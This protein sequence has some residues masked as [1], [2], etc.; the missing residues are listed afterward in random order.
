M[1]RVTMRVLTIIALLLFAPN[2]LA[3]ESCDP[4]DL[5]L[6][7]DPMHPAHLFYVGTCNYRNGDYEDAAKQWRALVTIE[8]IDSKYHELQVSAHNNLGYLLFFGYGLDENKT[9]ALDH[10]DK[11]ISLGHTESE[12]HLCHAYGDIGVSTYD[13]VKA[14]L[15]CEKA[16]LIY[17]GI[18]NRDEDQETI[19]KSIREYRNKLP[20]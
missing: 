14:Q 16:E 10:W 17:K 1:S 2:V 19:L 6:V 5:N 12:Y 3:K 7:S 13:P 18:E 8:S 9:E 20:E 11:A 4:K 15:H